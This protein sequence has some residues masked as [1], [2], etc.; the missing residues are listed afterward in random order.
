MPF[1][2][3][4]MLPFRLTLSFLF[5]PF[6]R[7]RKGFQCIFL[8]HVNGIVLR[9]WECGMLIIMMMVGDYMEK[10]KKVFALF[11]QSHF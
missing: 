2:W 3:V 10:G 1:V 4:T 11:F 6:F 7:K 9:V 5:P 8:K